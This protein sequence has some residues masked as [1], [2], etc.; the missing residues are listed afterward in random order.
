MG[1]INWIKFGI[2]WVLCFFIRM[3][4]FRPPNIEPVLAFQM[5]FAKRYG[6]FIG[7]VFAFLNIIFYDLLTA[8]LGPWTFITAVAYGS[9]GLWAAYFFRQR[10]GKTS[11]VVLDFCMQLPIFCN[12][13]LRIVQKCVSFYVMKSS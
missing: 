12:Q 3:L 7:F 13:V 5:P 2:G 8:G 9:L 6:Y 11:C 4:P 1:K 10:K